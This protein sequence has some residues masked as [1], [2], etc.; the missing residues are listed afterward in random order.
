MRRSDIAVSELA[1]YSKCRYKDT[2]T[3]TCG[4]RYIR[5]PDLGKLASSASLRLFKLSVVSSPLLPLTTT[6]TVLRF[7]DIQ[8]SHPAINNAIS[9]L[10][11]L[12]VMQHW[13]EQGIGSFDQ[14]FHRADG[15]N[16]FLSPD[17]R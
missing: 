12:G 4:Y 14:F 1:H 5:W 7:N 8:V 2:R 13:L 15:Y 11:S 6:S 10:I 3:F 16:R 17:W 9:M